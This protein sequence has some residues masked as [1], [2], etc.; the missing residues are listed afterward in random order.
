MAN[1]NT[2]MVQI[3]NNGIENGMELSNH[4]IKVYGR[5]ITMNRVD[6]IRPMSL[7]FF[8]ENI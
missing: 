3:I 7:K 5:T 2:D 4:S 1:K 6:T 8:M